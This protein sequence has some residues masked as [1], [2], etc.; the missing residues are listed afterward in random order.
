MAASFVPSIDIQ[1][2]AESKQGLNHTALSCIGTVHTVVD[3]SSLERALSFLKENTGRL[4]S[5]LDV[6]AISSTDDV[7]SILDAGASQII[8]SQEQAQQLQKQFENIDDSR[9]VVVQA[10]PTR[11]GKSGAAVYLPDLDQALEYRSGSGKNTEQ[12]VVFVK[13]DRAEK[14]AIEKAITASIVPIVPATALTTNSKANPELVSVA[15]LL[16][17]KAE[18]DRPDGLYTTLVTD[19]RDVALGLVYSSR[20]SV[21]ESL[22]TGRGV[23][24]SRKRGLWYKG[25]SSGDVQELV[26]VSFDCDSDCLKF[27]VRQKGRGIACH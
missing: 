11:S 6:T 25:E 27:V 19:E 13:L 12:E 4:S 24:Q 2:C 1:N 17:V 16:L 5:I 26:H 21:A 3:S 20:E 9:L 8:I 18:S 14:A 7:V 23:Y 22:R 15:E 10:G